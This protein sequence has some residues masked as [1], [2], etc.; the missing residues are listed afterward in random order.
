MAKIT[1]FN[2]LLLLLFTTCTANNNS[3]IMGFDYFCDYK[4]DPSFAQENIP[5]ASDTLPIISNCIIDED[6]YLHILYLHFGDNFEK[7]NSEYYYRVLITSSEEDNFVFVELLSFYGEGQ[8]KLVKRL[9]VNPEIFGVDYYNGIPIVVN[10]LTYSK[11][12]FMI[13]KEEKII[14]FDTF[15]FF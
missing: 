13:N 4:S 10:W 7:E 12:I 3:L 15:D 14:D 11:V 9:E 6:M 8:L 2:F 1:I 5:H